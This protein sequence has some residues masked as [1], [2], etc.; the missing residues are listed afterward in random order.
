MACGEWPS[1]T[2]TAVR[3]EYRRDGKPV[4]SESTRGFVTDPRRRYEDTGFV[5][6]LHTWEAIF[7]WFH[8]DNPPE[9]EAYTAE[10]T[11]RLERSLEQRVE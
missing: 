7:G 2:G 4:R 5:V 1:P 3:S 6:R 11:C 8:E 10:R 9:Y